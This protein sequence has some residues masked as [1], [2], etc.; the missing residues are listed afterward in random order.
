MSQRVCSIDT[1]AA[2]ASSSRPGPLA[3][4]RVLDL[5]AY[6]AAPYGCSLL[7]D[8]GADVIKIEPP[9]GD[10]FRRYPSTLEGE[11]RAFL[12]VN[13]SKRGIVLDLKSAAG[14]AVLGRLIDRAD[15]LVH[16]FRPAVPARLGIDYETVRARNPGLIYCALSGYGEHGPL[17]DNAG[18]DQVLQSFTGMAAMQ[19]NAE[20]GPQL[21]YG[22]VVDYYAAAMIA[23]GVASALYE[24]SCSGQGQCI[25][26]S[27]LRSAL[28]MQSARLVWADCEPR[29]RNRDMRSGGVTGIHPTREGHLYLS[30]NTP[31][32]WAALCEKAGLPAAA[33]GERYDSVRKR[34]EHASEIVPMLRAALLER[35]ALQWEAHF[36]SEVPCAAVRT[37][38]DMFSHPQVIAESMIGPIDHPVVGRYRG[39][40]HPVTFG[41]TP[42]GDPGAAPVLGQ[43]SIAVLQELGFTP[44]EI[45]ALAVAF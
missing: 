13:R 21:L 18:Y 12:G 25:G 14:R 43:H 20:Q 10:N 28:A 37:V 4:V 22:S 38:E 45:E 31:R 2:A 40:R 16:S 1:P 39:F 27:L 5:G 26:V 30:A 9:E 32:F 23:S 7:A 11:G 3:G 17:R 35:S 34:N 24:R 19:G 6:I 41:R 29:E 8:Q 33:R 36:G 42:A 15:V 44:A